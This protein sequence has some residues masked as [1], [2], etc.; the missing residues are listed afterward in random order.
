M[1]E[2]LFEQM[3]GTYTRQG[4]YLLP[5]LIPLAQGT[6][7]IGV[8]GEQRR[9]YFKEHRRVLHYNLLTSGK[10]QP[11]LADVEEQTQKMFEQLTAQMVEKQGVAE[12][13]KAA[14]MMA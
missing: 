8:W 13:L 7:N 14:D 11:H 2:A 6:R 3:G 4:D 12:A 9:K 5:D 1:K 10:R